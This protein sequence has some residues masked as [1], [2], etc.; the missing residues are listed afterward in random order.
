MTR[1]AICQSQEENTTKIDGSSHPTAAFLRLNPHHPPVKEGEV[2]TALFGFAQPSE[3]SVSDGWD[4]AIYKGGVQM[5]LKS[6]YI[7]P[8]HPAW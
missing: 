1:V 6:V 2:S 4:I 7:L 5:G 8:C 3:L